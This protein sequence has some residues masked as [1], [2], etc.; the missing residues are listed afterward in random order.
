VL[1]PGTFVGGAVSFEVQEGSRVVG[2]IGPGGYLCWERPPGEV[3]LVDPKVTY[4]TLRFEAEK[5][6]T[7]YVGWSISMFDP[8]P[9]M[10]LLSEDAGRK[11]LQQCSH[12]P[13]ASAK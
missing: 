3:S 8:S 2:R 13:K 12:K 4:E 10:T 11:T 1:R 7:Y 9:R 5:G 6:R